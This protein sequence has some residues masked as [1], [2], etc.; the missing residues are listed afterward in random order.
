MRD[1]ARGCG[2]TLKT[3][4]AAISGAGDDVM[5]VTFGLTAFDDAISSHSVAISGGGDGN[6]IVSSAQDSISATGGGGNGI[7]SR[8]SDDA[9]SPV[10]NDGS[11]G[12]LDGPGGGAAG[13]TSSVL[14]FCS[15]LGSGLGDG[16]KTFSGC[17]MTGNVVMRTH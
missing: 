9:L 7:K 17:C 1:K 11:D 8:P 5:I 4:V 12:N 16:M 2:V 14:V 13:E 3:S 6:V 15:E 10:G